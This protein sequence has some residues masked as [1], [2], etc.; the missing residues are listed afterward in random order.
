MKTSAQRRLLWLSELT[1]FCGIATL[2]WLSFE[3]AGQSTNL[4][5]WLW[6]TRGAHGAPSPRVGVS[7]VWTGT[8]MLVWGG[9]WGGTY[10]T[11]ETNGYRYDPVTDSWSPMSVKNA[12]TARSLH[13]AIWTGRELIIW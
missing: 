7:T 4:D 8:R 5:T 6:S 10:N 1:T 2:T 9:S 12:P 13:T 11:S 3:A